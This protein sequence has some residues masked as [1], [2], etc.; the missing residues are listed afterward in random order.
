MSV[1]PGVIIESQGPALSTLRALPLGRSVLQVNH[2]NGR[3]PNYF[4]A[5]HSFSSGAML[6][7]N[8][9]RQGVPSG[10]S[11]HVVI[12]GGA[13]SESSNASRRPGTPSPAG[14]SSL[15]VGWARG[16]TSTMESSASSSF[17]FTYRD[18]PWA[19]T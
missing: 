17:P 18:C 2:E 12:V 3:G 7:P 10:S 11:D 6:T 9:V 13:H 16:T 1:C 19:T 14:F 5:S 15:T 8:K 4:T